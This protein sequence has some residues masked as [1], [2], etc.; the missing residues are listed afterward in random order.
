MV[1]AIHG[2]FEHSH[3]HNVFPGVGFQGQS[4]FVQGKP[5]S[6]SIL[7]GLPSTSKSTQIISL[8]CFLT[9]CTSKVANMSSY[10]STSTSTSTACTSGV[11]VACLGLPC[12]F[13][14]QTRWI[15]PCFLVL[16]K[17]IVCQMR[18]PTTAVARGGGR[19]FRW[20]WFVVFSQLVNVRD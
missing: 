2:Y 11:L 19:R 3:W 1:L 4:S 17:T 7:S 9:L 8:L 13:E 5:V 10:A 16:V 12:C 18:V 14:R 15:W 20:C 6:S